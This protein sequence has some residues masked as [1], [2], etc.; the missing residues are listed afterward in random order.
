MV[1]NPW[2]NRGR[3]RRC[4]GAYLLRNCSRPCLR[5]SMKES[6][7]IPSSP[8]KG[9]CRIRAFP[10]RGGTTTWE[11]QT[12]NRHKWV[13]IAKLSI[14]PALNVEDWFKGRWHSNWFNLVGASWLRG[15]GHLSA[16]PCF[17]SPAPLWATQSHCIASEQRTPSAWRWVGWSVD[18]NIQRGCKLLTGFH[19]S[20]LF[21]LTEKCFHSWRRKKT[22]LNQSHIVCSQA[23]LQPL[24]CMWSWNAYNYLDNWW[25]TVFRLMV[26]S[27]LHELYRHKFGPTQHGSNHAEIII[28]T[29][30]TLKKNVKLKNYSVTVKETAQTSTHHLYSVRVEQETSFS[31]ETTSTMSPWSMGQCLVQEGKTSFQPLLSSLNAY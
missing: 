20:I 23:F 31:A 8:R 18:K 4:G 28:F 5:S 16:L 2:K 9:S 26:S 7:N 24:E 11:N 10:G 22:T 6:S 19:C 3:W 13:M 29:W 1:S 14:V 12:S 15:W 17:P 27:D 25:I 21:W 30:N